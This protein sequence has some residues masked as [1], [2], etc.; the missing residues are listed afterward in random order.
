MASSP[1]SDSRTLLGS[2][3]HRARFGSAQGMLE[4]LF[5]LA[6]KGLV[7]PQIWEDPDVDL[8]ALRL[9]PES[10]ILTIASGGCNVL[11]Y[12]TA[13]PRQIVAV[14]LNPAHVALARLKLAAI[15]HLPNYDSFYRFFGEAD[16]K[17][18]I[19]AYRRFLRD[20]LDPEARAY[21]EAR[22]LTNWGR[23]RIS[24]FSRDL[25]RHGLLGHF[26]GFAHIV[27]RL[28]G[29]D[30]KR[31]LSARS[32]EEQRSYFEQKLAPIFDKRVVRW[33]TSNKLSLFGLGI[34]PAQYETLLAGNPSMAQVLKGR[35]ERLA[36]G[37]P[38]GENYFAWQAFS[39]GYAPV[40]PGST[41]DTGPLPP[42]LK[43]EHFEAIRSRAGRVAV[44]NRSV[45]DQLRCEADDSLDAVVLLD[46][47]DWMTDVQLDEL[48]TEVTRAAKP[49]G[50]V[51]FRTAAPHT[52]LP[53]RIA[54]GL[55][56]RWTYLH[57][58]S[59]ALGQQDRSSIY[60]GFHLYV[61]NA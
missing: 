18:N 40:Q 38:V 5:P 43:R 11:S 10:R 34:P 14:D 29:V 15:M 26:I 3:V 50:R 20:R 28:Y 23:K 7:Y 61:R 46:A 25:Y 57:R 45:V 1:R 58:E 19:A 59:L 55:L 30:P 44:L 42:Y 39:R 60:G 12:L 13:D 37:F 35:L 54:D 27:A 47:Q 31:L 17:A 48:W 2:A 33:M 4:R 6:F 24:L 32:I 21:W 16:E 36:C 49:G 52:L 41:K 56:S 8:Q 9:P 22:A 53:G 51:V